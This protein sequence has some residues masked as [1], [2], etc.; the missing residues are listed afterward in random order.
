MPIDYGT[1]CAQC[2]FKDALHLP[3]ADRTTR[4]S[5][6][7]MERGAGSVLMIFQAPG[8]NEWTN[9]RPICSTAPSSAGG[10]LAA[11]FKEA[12]RARSEYN[13]TNTVQC[14]PGKKMASTASRSRDKSPPASVRNHC[15]NWLRED[16]ESKEYTRVVVFGSHAKKA[17]TK[18]GYAD[19]PKFRFVKHPTGGLSKVEL[20]NTVA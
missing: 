17:V 12:G 14:F 16:I 2:E 7:A 6:L 3:E 15:A 4:S 10:R 9:G 11:A 20:L 5:P 18:L 8:I 13:I 19:D 1:H